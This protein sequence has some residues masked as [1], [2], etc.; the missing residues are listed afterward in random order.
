MR[1]DLLMPTTFTTSDG[2]TIEAEL[3]VPASPGLGVVITHPH[4]EAGGTMFTPVPARLLA[5]CRDMG[6]LALRFNFRGVGQSTGTHGDDK[7]ER[8]DVEA[9]VARL[10]ETVPGV[11]ILIAGYSFGADVGLAVGGPGVAGW[12]AAAPPLQFVP[13][14]E[15]A[16]AAAADPTLLLVP[17][18]DDF[19]PPAAAKDAT[20][21]WSNTTLE[22]VPG[23][24]HFFTGELDTMAESF[25]RFAKSLL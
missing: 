24:D 8:L 16:A 9:A 2:E 23:A 1:D 25:E 4:P 21:G 11:P 14:E 6:L 15:N 5:S 18:H 12:M 22:V 7:A 17:E 3:S 19:L 13:V 10:Q 20:A